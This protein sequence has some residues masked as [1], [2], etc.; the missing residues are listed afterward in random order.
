VKERRLRLV[1][2]LFILLGV[3][4]NLDLEIE[5]LPWRRYRYLLLLGVIVG[6]L[7]TTYYTCWAHHSLDGRVVD[8]CRLRCLLLHLDWYSRIDY[9]ERNSLH[10][11]S[12]DCC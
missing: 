4:Y 5:S 12:T 9:W 3:G 1:L 7:D 11:F 6:L 8:S 10:V 2:G